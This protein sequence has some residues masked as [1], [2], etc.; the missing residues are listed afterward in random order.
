MKNINCLL[1][2]GSILEKVYGFL[3]NQP[4]IMSRKRRIII[5]KENNNMAF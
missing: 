5:K 2:T 1:E 4:E 3:Q